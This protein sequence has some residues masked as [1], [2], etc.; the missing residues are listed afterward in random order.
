MKE[1]LATFVFALVAI[2]LLVVYGVV[3]PYTFHTMGVWCGAAPLPVI[4]ADFLQVRFEYESIIRIVIFIL[5]FL[6]TGYVVDKMRVFR[7]NRKI[8]IVVFCTIS[9]LIIAYGLLFLYSFLREIH[10]VSP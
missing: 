8:I 4:L 3:I 9:S 6:I 5:C 2:L 1:F 10:R 7:S